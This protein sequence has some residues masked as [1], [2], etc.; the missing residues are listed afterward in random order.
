MLQRR[1]GL[2]FRLGADLGEDRLQREDARRER[3][4]VAVDCVA[5]QAHERGGFVVR[6]G[7]GAYPNWGRG[8]IL[9]RSPP[10]QACGV[11]RDLGYG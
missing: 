11:P 4:A 10:P 5:Q 2:A 3:V 9:G 6:L 7:R 8:V 1:E